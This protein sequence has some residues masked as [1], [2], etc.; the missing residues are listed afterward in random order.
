MYWVDDGTEK[1]IEKA[2]MDGRMRTVLHDINL[3]S[4]EFVGLTLDYTT[5]T[6][7]W[8]NGHEIHSSNVNGLGR[9]QLTTELPDYGY[10]IT[11]FDNVLYYQDYNYRIYSVNIS[12]EGGL[13]NT[14]SSS[15]DVYTCGHGI[16]LISE[17]RQPQGK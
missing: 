9:K 10:G 5:Q 3:E 14:L 15:T 2:S 11:A 13:V 4:Q 8:I 6:L 12:S 1:R 17:Q 7:Y 16:Q